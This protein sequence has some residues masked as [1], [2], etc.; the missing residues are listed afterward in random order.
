MTDCNHYDIFPM[1]THYRLVLCTCPDNESATR[2]AQGLV[3]QHLAA[4]VN[5]IP[6]LTSVYAWKGRI[7]TDQEVLLLIKS[8]GD[9]LAALQAFIREHHPYELPEIVAVPIE[10][11]SRDY[12]AWLGDWLDASP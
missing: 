12:L 3:T 9:R 8:R 1:S 7:E 2:L 6:G 11:G 5:V 10:E 4:C